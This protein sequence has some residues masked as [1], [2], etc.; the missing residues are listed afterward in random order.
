MGTDCA[1]CDDLGTMAMLECKLVDQFKEI[2]R[3]K[4]QVK[5]HEVTIKILKIGQGA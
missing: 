5:D 2:V 3:L 1:Q 4:E